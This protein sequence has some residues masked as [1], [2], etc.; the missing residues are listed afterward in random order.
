[1]FAVICRR[2]LGHGIVTSEGA[3]WKQQRAVLSPAFHVTALERMVPVFL[4]ASA[5]LRSAAAAA[6]AC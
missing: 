2:I 5:R 6:V 3:L 1:V 4:S